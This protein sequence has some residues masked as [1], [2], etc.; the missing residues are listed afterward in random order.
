MEIDGA[1]A[2]NP[3]NNMMKKRINNKKEPII[4]LDEDAAADIPKITAIIAVTTI[5]GVN[6]IKEIKVVFPANLKKL[7]FKSSHPV[8][9]VN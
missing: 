4:P 9:S 6:I 1:T 8:V 2:I 7:S 5:I 3:P